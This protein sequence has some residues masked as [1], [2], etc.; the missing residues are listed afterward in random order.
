MRPVICPAG[1][2]SAQS[3]SACTPP[4]AL[5]TPS[6]R[7]I[8]VMPSAAA[9]SPDSGAGPALGPA[10]LWPVTTRRC[11]VGSTPRGRN[12][13]TTRNSAPKRISRFV[14]VGLLEVR[15]CCVG[16]RI[17]APEHRAGHRAEAAEER[18][19]HHGQV[20]QRVEDELRERLADEV[21]PQAAR[22][23]GDEGGDHQRGQLDRHGP[24]RRGR[25]PGPR[26]RGWPAAAGRTATGGSARTAPPWPPR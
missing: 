13:I 8:A 10:A 11:P 21:D 6:V 4:K 25:R 22:H 19:Q 14:A 20:E 12:R 16:S 9:R 7:S 15:Y 1:A 3:A 2:V 24:A 23:P 26:R 17:S 5:V 18:H